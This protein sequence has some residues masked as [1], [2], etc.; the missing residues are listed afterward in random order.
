[1]DIAHKELNLGHTTNLTIFFQ[2][3]LFS[4]TLS[5]V[6]RAREQPSKTE[7]KCYER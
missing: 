3:P 4:L 2:S 7:K 6:H 1:M 5:I